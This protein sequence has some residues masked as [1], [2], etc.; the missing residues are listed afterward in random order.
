MINKLLCQYKTNPFSD[1]KCDKQGMMRTT[2]YGTTIPICD[3]H[4]MIHNQH[5]KMLQEEGCVSCGLPCTT[6]KLRPSS[7]GGYE[8]FCKDCIQEGY[9]IAKTNPKE[10]EELVQ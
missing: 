5:L 7:D 2:M 1:D 8:L 3:T 6:K 4:W 9:A 10:R